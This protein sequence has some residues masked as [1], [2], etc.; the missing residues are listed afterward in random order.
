MTDNEPEIDCP[1]C[2]GS[3]IVEDYDTWQHR[4]GKD[5]WLKEYTCDRCD[6]TG[7]VDS[8]DYREEPDIRPM[9]DDERKRAMERAGQNDRRN[10]R[11]GGD[12]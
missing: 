3:G 4:A 2:S 8:P 12:A 11:T 6:G 1:E 5:L 9:T 10:I 7:V